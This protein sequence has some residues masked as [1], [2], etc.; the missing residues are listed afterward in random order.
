MRGA[1]VT[2]R[3][4]KEKCTGET[5]REHTQPESTQMRRWGIRLGRALSAGP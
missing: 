3:K 4:A 2:G 1:R 5:D